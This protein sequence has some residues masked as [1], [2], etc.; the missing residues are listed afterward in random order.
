M[1]RLSCVLVASSLGLAGC[2]TIFG[3]DEGELMGPGG[4]GGAAGDGGMAGAGGGT[5]GTA[6]SGGMA[7]SGGSGGAGG[8]SGPVSDEFDD[9]TTL[10]AC[11]TQV[12]AALTTTFDIDTTNPDQLT[13]VPVANSGSWQESI[14][15]FL[16]KE[17]TGDFLVAAYVV[18][19]NALFLGSAPT[20]NY[21]MAG[22]FVRRPI[23][24]GP[25]NLDED[26]IKWE[27]GHRVDNLMPPDPIPAVGTL[28]ART[29]SSSSAHVLPYG[30]EDT[31][32]SGLAICRVGAS[33]DLYRRLASGDWA[34]LH[35]LVQGTSAPNLPD[36]I[37]VGVIAGA[38]SAQLADIQA[39]FEYVRF[40]PVPPATLSECETMLETMAP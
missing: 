11:W 22:L 25:P 12:N 5:G 15:P 6:G 26:W 39:R 18:A 32:E 38:F 24:V 29:V 30:E 3:I 16:Y 8:C 35:A 28:A 37:Q 17:I 20:S 10:S 7:G 19:E 23:A 13:I 14:A 34:V 2:N 31:H 36:T 33:F 27:I 1:Q 9:P 40:A 4:S 21:N